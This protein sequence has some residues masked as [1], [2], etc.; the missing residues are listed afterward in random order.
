MRKST[1]YIALGTLLIF[2][3]FYTCTW[4]FQ[5]PWAVVLN[6]CTLNLGSYLARKGKQ[7]YNLETGKPENLYSLTGKTRWL[8]P[9]VSNTLLIV[10][11]VVAFLF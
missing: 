3:G 6:L 5:S 7:L 4:V 10:V 8:V 1:I 11:I 9:I 2:S